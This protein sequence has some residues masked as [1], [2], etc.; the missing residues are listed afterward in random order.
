[1]MANPVTTTKLP[2]GGIM[3]RTSKQTL[4]KREESYQHYMLITT[5]KYKQNVVYSEVLYPLLPLSCEGA[6]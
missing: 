2:V 5:P 3:R 1:M 4:G 6:I